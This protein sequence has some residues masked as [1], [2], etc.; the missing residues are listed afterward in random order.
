MTRLR[1][2]LHN[3][4]TWD[5]RKYDLTN[6]YRQYDPDVILIT[7]HGLKDE[8]KLKI[9]GYRVYKRNTTNEQM[10]G[11]AIAIRSR[12]QHRLDDDFLSETLS[13]TTDTTDGPLTLATMYLPPR[14]PYLPHPDIIKL[15]RQ[16][17]PVFLAGDLNARHMTFGHATANRVGR[18][19]LQYI[20]HQTV[21]HVG[22]AFP[23]YFGPLTS[24]TP[25]IILKNDYN[26][27][28]HTLT[29]GPMTT[30][31][32]I[33]I[34][35][36]ISTSPILVPA[37]LHYSFHRTDWDAFKTDEDLEMADLPDLAYGTLEDI[38]AALETWTRTVQTVTDR[39][40]PSSTYKTPP[41]PRPSRQTQLLRIQFQALIDRAARVGW[42]I[43]D[44]RRYVQLRQTLQEVRRGEARDYWG[45]TLTDLAD[46]YHNP[47][48][49]WQKLKCLS[50]RTTHTNTYLL[51]DHGVK[52]HKDSD[53]ERLFTDIWEGVFGEDNDIDNNLNHDIVHDFLTINEHRTHTHATADPARLDG[54]SYL[55]CG[56]SAEELRRAVRASRPT[57][58]GS[59]GINRILMSNL[60][61]GALYRLR[62]I[63]N[64]A[65]SAG[66]FP[67][68]LKAAEMRMIPKPGKVLTR[69]DSYRP[70]SLLEVPGKMLERVVARR[71]NHYLETE[72][73]YGE[74]Q[75]GFRRGRGTVHAIALATE[76]LAIHQAN[77]F[78]CNLV[79]RDVSKAFD[80]VWHLGLKYKILQLGLPGHV[81]RLLCDFLDDRS[82]RVRVGR[83]LGPPFQLHT[84][85]PQGSVL[86]PLLYAI[87]TRDCPTSRAG[88]NVQY[89][90]DVSQ[91]V[92]HPGR[93]SHMLNIRTG[94][95]IHRVNTYEA[96]WKIQTNMA[97]FT[98]IPIVTR[99]PAPLLVEDELVDFRPRG[100][101]LGLKVSSHGYKIHITQRVAQAREALNT[102]QRFRDLSSDLKLRLVKTL[103]IPVLTYPPVPTHAMSRTAISR[104]Q[105]VQNAALRFTY[106]V[107]W[108]DFVSNEELHMMA[109]L[110]PINI[111]LHEMAEKVWRKLGSQEGDLYLALQRL[112]ADAP[113]RQ[114]HLF[115]RSLLR[116][117]REPDPE[118]CYY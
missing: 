51:D 81:E 30:S 115:P 117:E 23:T 76:A 66:Y 80:R 67:D 10:D 89:A 29:P 32:H 63:F 34:I 3:V 92:F 28:F 107:K 113:G 72:R 24:S 101:L 53:K 7:S 46:Q 100:S 96:E 2:I 4:L 97:K 70:I 64:A 95:E 45:R 12:L 50:G 84:G 58:P 49:F 91:V 27:L 73:L 116:L 15:F 94:R 77:R 71:L 42:T 55:T 16:H 62:D 109:S 56:V 44:Y 17:S 14:R 104:L 118:P 105:K 85:V 106:N 36:D 21:R 74:A 88:L 41:A 22:P 57:A 82:A 6:T 78:R 110:Q 75:Y 108:Q 99:N 87:Y 83:H 59:S 65:L 69:A 38:D 86:S 52:Q 103:V 11:V 60:P 18:D 20:R 40:V 93:S 112:H 98:A 102:L 26:F 68:G 48:L 35:M 43:D 19:L 90:D 5:T 37:N 114:H 39:H 8:D 47:R 25:D 54:G 13:V 1:V 111:R 79:L 33:P 9:P 31:D 61:D